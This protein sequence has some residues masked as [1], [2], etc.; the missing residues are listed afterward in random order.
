MK[1]ASS[2]SLKC[3][4]EV[5]NV[6]NTDLCHGCG[7]ACQL[8]LTICRNTRHFGACMATFLS[9][10]YPVLMNQSLSQIH[11]SKMN[12]FQINSTSAK[13]IFHGTLHTHRVVC[14]R[15]YLT[16]NVHAHQSDLT[17][18]Q[19]TTE[20][21]VCMVMFIPIANRRTSFI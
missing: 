10:T 14:K 3:T 1:C 5:G 9:L 21:F 8:D 11:I 15:D 18:C 12:R 2:F 13:D 17:I 6:F 4:R 16:E 20:K 7:C 19:N